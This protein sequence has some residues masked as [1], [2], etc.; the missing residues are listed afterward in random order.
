M[1]YGRVAALVM[2][3]TLSF[4]AAVSAADLQGKSLLGEPLYITQQIGFPP[5][6]ME[7][8]LKATAEAKTAF[9]Q[10][11]TPDTATWYARLLMYQNHI[12]DSIAVLDRGLKQY[13]TSGKLLRHRAQRY[14]TLREF[15]KSIA[16][17]LAGVKYYEGQPIEREKPG[18]AYFPGDPD[19]VQ[20][21]LHYHLG[22]AYFGKHNYDNAQKSFAKA[23]EIASF[24][25]DNDTESST[26][27]WMFLCAARAG[28][29]AEARDILDGYKQTLFEVHPKGDSDTYFDGIQLFKGNRPVS[30]MFSASDGGQPFATADGVIASTSYSIAQYY[31]LMGER[32]KAKPWLA[33]SIQIKGWGYFARI[34]AEADWKQMFPNEVPAPVSDPAPK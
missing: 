15:D 9:E 2:I 3:G 27:Y 23:R 12:L 20:M 28:R 14:L 4:G 34:Q 19:M 5:A 21:Y 33:R 25:R 29:T 30:S 26:V 6:Q 10:S 24:S 13:P 11:V 16:D 31:L 8:L 32:E 17:G 1:R 18:P 22:Q 7:N